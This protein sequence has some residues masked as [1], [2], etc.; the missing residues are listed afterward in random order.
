M[1]GNTAVEDRTASI[2]PA[3]MG[4]IDEQLGRFSYKPSW[5]FKLERERFNEPAIVISFATEDAYNPGQFIRPESIYPISW[6]K[7]TDSEVFKNW[8]LAATILVEMH[9]CQEMFVRDGARV[10]EPHSDEVRAW[11]LEMYDLINNAAMAGENPLLTVL[12]A[13]AAPAVA[14]GT[15]RPEPRKVTAADRSCIDALA[16]NIPIRA[17]NVG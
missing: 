11:S 17:F 1:H 7:I 5:E 3:H 16:R 10:F 15:V 4:W 2:D 9:E 13:A 12:F 14:A 6:C 8:L